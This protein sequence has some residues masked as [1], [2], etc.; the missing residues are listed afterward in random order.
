MTMLEIT[1]SAHRLID[2]STGGS[3][4][5]LEAHLQRHGSLPLPGADA[6]EWGDQLLDEIERSGLTGRGGAGFPSFKKL[7]LAQLGAR[8]TIVVNA[9]EGEPASRKD[10]YL[11]ASSPHLVLDGAELLARA[12]RA[13]RILVCV[14]VEEDDP[15]QRLSRALYER[16][17]RR[18][19]STPTEIRK[20]P[21]RYVAGEES[22]LVA[23]AGGGLGVPSFRP[24][25][26][27]P[28]RIGRDVA[29]VHNVE[30]LANVALIGR[31][32]ASWF[33]QVGS[34]EAPGTCLVTVSGGVERPGVIE[35]VIGTPVRE[36]LEI[37]R[38]LGTVQA[39]LVGGYAGAWLSG[40]DASTPF[41]PTALGR[42]DA[43]MGAGVLV[44]LGTG[45]CGIRET[46]RIAR[47][48][49]SE[50]AGQCGP[51]LFGLPAIADDLR[52]I[53]DGRGDQKTLD[54]LV[55]RCSAVVGRGAC[56]HPDGVAR[57]VRT[58]LAVF[59]KDVEVHLH[60]SAC[61]ASRHESVLMGRLSI[62]R[63]EQ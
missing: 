8:A 51:C 25:K 36:I 62:S 31:H 61:S 11:V 55:D 52:S 12:L 50:S 38:P 53:A 21:G 2:S 28:L 47:F 59:S 32:G 56:R 41:A 1:T 54:R 29:L 26:S 19:P 18:L 13:N 57:L 34:P 4:P 17:L 22:A 49:A 10:R 5:S 9:M 30:T 48:M 27:I 35:V 16:A 40:E 15:A 23:G 39:V 63:R 58:A 42:L 3:R 44:V 43:S 24:D 37:A 60:G 20:L 46:E 6:R 45:S 7:R 33:K 14:P